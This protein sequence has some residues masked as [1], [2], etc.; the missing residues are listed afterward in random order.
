MRCLPI[1]F[2]LLSVFIF[3]GCGQNL[4]PKPEG[5]PKLY[6]C[7]ISVTFGGEAK[8]GVRAVLEPEDEDSKWKPNGMTNDE[9]KVIPTTTYGYQGVPT[10]TYTLSFSLIEEPDDEAPRGT[11]AVSL[12]PLKY[13]SGQSQ[14]KLEIKAGKNEF[15]F[16]LD[17]GQEKIPRTKKR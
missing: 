1:I 5:L 15:T 2:A 17:G 8:G 13:S 16:A 12:I 6:P 10:G 3:A 4:P 14:E 11:P 9:G 7:S